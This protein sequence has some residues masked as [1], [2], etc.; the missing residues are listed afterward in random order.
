MRNDLQ[1]LK[2]ATEEKVLRE[3]CNNGVWNASLKQSLSH[4]GTAK[5]RTAG[6]MLLQLLEYR[7]QVQRF[8][9]TSSWNLSKKKEKIPQAQ[10]KLP[11]TVK[12]S[13]ELEM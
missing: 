1:V 6:C 8:S 10:E 2:K 12:G 3:I 13:E 7:R 5:K 9:V 4:T 11:T